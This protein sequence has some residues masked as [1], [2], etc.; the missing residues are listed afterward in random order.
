[1]TVDHLCR[2]A[3]ERAALALLRDLV[4][5]A[6]GGPM[7]RHGARVFLIA[8]ELARRAGIPA[9]REVL[10]IAA[11]LHDAGLYTSAEERAQV[12]DSRDLVERLLVGHGWSSARVRLSAD[13]VEHH[14]E[15]RPQW[16][17]G[18]E[19]ELIRRA[20]LGDGVPGHPLRFGLDH[21]WLRELDRRVPA[22]GFHRELARLLWRHARQRPVAAFLRV[23]HPEQA[24]GDG[25]DGAG[26]PSWG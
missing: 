22:D 25:A 5:G 12:A 20:D 1:M 4:G 7:E 24:G 2:S 6:E 8:E 10:L 18:D 14:H 11:L 16:R 15:I 26:R 9:D 19:V 3:A 23:F 13:A 17:R 21:A